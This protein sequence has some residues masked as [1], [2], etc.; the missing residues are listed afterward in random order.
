MSDL[1]QIYD[2]VGALFNIIDLARCSNLVGLIAK[3]LSGSGSGSGRGSALD[4]FH[5]SWL[6]RS[7]D[8][9]NGEGEHSDN[10]FELHL[11]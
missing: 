5:S 2:L 11:G 8:Y 10:G 9:R 7:G 4:E 6:D 1:E 3:R